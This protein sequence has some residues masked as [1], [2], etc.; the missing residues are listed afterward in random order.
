MGGTDV[1]QKHHHGKRKKIREKEE[2]KKRQGLIYPDDTFYLK[3]VMLIIFLLFYTAT[4][5]AYEI[6]FSVHDGEPTYLMTFSYII[7]FIF[8][9]DLLLQF[10]TAT[11]NPEGKLIWKKSELAKNYLCS[12]FILDFLAIFPYELFFNDDTDHTFLLVLLKM[13]KIKKLLKCFHIKKVRYEQLKDNYFEEKTW[14][15]FELERHVLTCI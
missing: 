9:I 1:E 2:F 6:S 5:V 3:W 14:F 12:W 4:V 11:Y 15:T 7:D 13:T 8:F 10:F